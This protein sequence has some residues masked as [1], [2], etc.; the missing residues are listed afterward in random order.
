MGDFVFENWTHLSVT[1]NMVDV[2]TTTYEDLPISE[3][4]AQIWQKA[5]QLHSK[6]V[7]NNKHT[8]LLAR[9]Q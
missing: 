6:S 1:V 5:L 3:Y 8:R 2:V 7:Q 9:H 4:M